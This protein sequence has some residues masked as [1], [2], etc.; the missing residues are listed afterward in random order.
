MRRRPGLEA[1]ISDPKGFAYKVRKSGEV[2]ITHHGRQAAVLR[3]NQAASF[4]AKVI[5]EDAQA[6]M[7]RATGNYRRGNERR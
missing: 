2:V 1:L 7:A 3:G 5:N 6:L 4:L